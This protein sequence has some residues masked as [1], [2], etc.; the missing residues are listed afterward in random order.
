VFRLSLEAVRR[1]GTHDPVAFSR[2][3]TVVVKVLSQRLRHS[4]QMLSS[5]GELTDWLAGSLV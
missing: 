4:N 5:V 3:L 2:I 1:L